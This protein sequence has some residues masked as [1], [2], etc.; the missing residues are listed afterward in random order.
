M[1]AQYTAAALVTE[2]RLLAAPASVHSIPT[3][4]DQEDHVSMGWTAARQALQ[5]A[6]HC[7]RVLGAELLAAAQGLE[8]RGPLSP[9]PASAAV[10][11][12]L[13]RT[14]HPLDRDRELA[15]DLAE[16]A[17]LISSGAVVEAARTALASVG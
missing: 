1:L 15:P 4:A 7:A 10:V 14:V 8:F 13:R 6:E 2:M 11:A 5:S 3:S 17:R 9:S 16:A 12:R